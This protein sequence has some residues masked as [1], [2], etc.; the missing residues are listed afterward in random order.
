MNYWQESTPTHRIHRFLRAVAR[1][2]SHDALSYPICVEESLYPRW[3]ASLP[4]GVAIKYTQI[5]NPLT[6][7]AIC[8]IARYRVSPCPED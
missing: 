8:L 7:F 2:S 5:L 1:L 3:F 6:R 4:A